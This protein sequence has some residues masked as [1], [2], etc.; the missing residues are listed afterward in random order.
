MYKFFKRVGLV[1]LVIVSFI[2]TEKATLVV[3][4]YDKLMLDIKENTSIY[5][6][7]KMESIIKDNTIIPGVT[8]K[9]V[10]ADKSY[11]NMKFNNKFDPNLI[12]YKL[13]YPKIRLKDNK[14]KYIIK[15]QKEEVSLIIK[16]NKSFNS[17]ILN[18]DDKVSFYM[19]NSFIK[20][21]TL[22]VSDLVSKKYTILNN[23]N[24]YLKNVVGQKNTY[25]LA[26][27]INDKILSQCK[28]NSHT[29]IPNIIFSNNY[30]KFNKELSSGS[31][32]LTDLSNYKSVLKIVKNKG[33]KIVS[34]D[35]LLSE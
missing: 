21:N 10:D 19:D 7:T 1:L 4:E 23:Q 20:N 16:I 12:S 9:T 33:Y 14:D 2:Y 11:S 3:K 32:I 34:L 25:C 17:S 5:N 27:D 15:T 13:D 8:G 30:F 35:E 26:K 24:D 22:L 18:I 28:S 29:V 6:K 31:I